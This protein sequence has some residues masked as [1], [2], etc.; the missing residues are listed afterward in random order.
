MYGGT[1][2]TFERIT[3]RDSV[4]VIGVMPDKKIL[5]VWDEQPDREGLLDMAGGQIDDG[6]TPEQ[7]AH[8]EFLEETGYSVGT[9]TP[10]TTQKMPGRVVL[11]N[12]YFVGRGLV[13]QA[14]PQQSPG[15]KIALRVFT[16]D[17]FL[18]LG[19]DETLR[20]MRIRI[21]LLEA[22]L[23]PKKKDMLY[24]LLYE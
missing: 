3:R 18:A 4:R 7:A 15:E 16:F 12:Y 20:D 10:I 22:Q 8:R 2:K 5:L 17:E 19:Q 6:E 21:T 11:S 23:D 9:L 14:E 1:T 13:K 24:K